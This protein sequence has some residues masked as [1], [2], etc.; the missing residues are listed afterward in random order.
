MS[1]FPHHLPPGSIA[2]SSRR[3]FLQA[4]GLGLLGVHGLAGQAQATPAAQLNDSGF[5]RAKRLIFIF[6]WG[7]PSHVDTFD[8]KPHAPAEIRGTFEPIATSAPGIQICEHFQ[9][10]A[11]LMDRVAIVRSL[12]HNDPA[13]LSSAH[14]LLTGHLPPVNK[15]DAIPPGPRDTPHI[16]S[17]IS[18]VMPNPP[19][20]PPFVTAPWIVS[21]PAA[22][23][24][25]AP[26]QNGGWLGRTYDPFLAEGNLA[27]PHW[28]I[29]SLALADGIPLNRLQHRETL[30]HEINR[31]QLALEAPAIMR[32][33]GEHARA[34]GLLASSS[35][36]SAFDL[37]EESDATRDRYGRNIHGQGV[38]LARRLIERDVPVVSVNW[39]NDGQNF[40][41]T[42]GDNFNRLKDTLIPSADMALSSLL[43]DL[44]E[45]GLL[46]DTIVAWVGEFGRK[47]IINAAAGREHHPFCY[48]GL[49]MGGGIRGGQ[50]YG[51]SDSRGYYPDASPVS[52]HDYNST[53]MH[54]LGINPE[55]TLLDASARP[56]AVYGG[57]PITSLFT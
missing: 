22:P 18:R 46:D 48:S 38:L 32:Q 49:L 17:V 14:T 55:M 2:S 8:M 30:L 31:Q 9:R 16:G 36:R 57:Q 52:P 40:W 56:H 47:P 13:H 45:R 39:H 43:T 37:S 7:G 42:H 34:A 20:L 1:V 51:V 5:G 44:T 24:G 53:L 54:A 35:V 15:T 12:N 11:P 4:G 3:V 10:L 25:K 50:T 26:G 33:E 27:D 21:H 41:D 19:G 28:S 29:P 6:M 23:G